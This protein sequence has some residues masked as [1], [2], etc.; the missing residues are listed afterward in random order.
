MKL[1]LNRGDCKVEE[2]GWRVAADGHSDVLV[3]VGLDPIQ[4]QGEVVAVVI[5]ET[6]LESLG[7][8]EGAGVE[9]HVAGRGHE[10]RHVIHRAL[11]LL[12]GG[13]FLE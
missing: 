5:L 4:V 9:G 10:R 3:R 13:H 2:V 6:G 1:H 8:V 12:R 7:V 11:A